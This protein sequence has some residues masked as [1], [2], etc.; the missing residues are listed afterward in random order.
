MI[1]AGI[2]V[3]IERVK[4]VI[5]KDRKLISKSISLSGFN[6]RKAAK[7]TLEKALSKAKLSREDLSYIVATGAGR[8]DIPFAND[9]VSVIK[10]NAKGI[11]HLSPATRIVIDVG[12]EES[13]AIRC[14]D[15]EVLD[16]AINDKCAAGAGSFIETMAS[17]L[18]VEVEKLDK[19]SLESKKKIEINAQCTIFAESEVISLLHAKV[20]KED[21]ARAINDAIAGRTSSLVYKVG[22]EEGIA[23][24]GGLARNPGFI[25]SLEKILGSKLLVPP[26]PEFVT[27]LGA[28]LITYEKK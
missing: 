20:D 22:K 19:L 23:L 2:D 11:G 27:A 15:G 7:R 3:G 1:V 9:Y 6:H 14:K 5:L 28:A 25:S 26:D 10:A 13:R 4:T 18:E 16:F 17:A 12:A 21:I 8:E 24:I